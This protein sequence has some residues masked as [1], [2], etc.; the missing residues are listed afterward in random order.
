[1]V[2][3]F[4]PDKRD[5]SQIQTP[6]RTHK[7]RICQE[8]S[9]GSSAPGS[10]SSLAARGLGAAFCSLN[11]E[12]SLQLA[13]NPPASFPCLNWASDALHIRSSV[14][15]LTSACKS[16]GSSVNN[17]EYSRKILYFFSSR[18]CQETHF[19]G[20]LWEAKAAEA[21]AARKHRQCSHDY[22]WAIFG[23]FA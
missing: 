21:K 17:K 23:V 13:A 2:L 18:F 20:Y 22:S 3:G 19:S 9:E 5:F 15:A 10:G 8:E 12:I 6:P 4:P 7:G 11:H 1:M 16:N 14:Q